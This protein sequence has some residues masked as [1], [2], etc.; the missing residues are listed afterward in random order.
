MN[1]IAP[2]TLDPRLQADAVFTQPAVQKR[3]T[4]IEGLK[5]A[6]RVH[7]AR[8]DAARDRG[9]LLIGEP[10]ISTSRAVDLHPGFAD[11]P[12]GIRMGDLDSLTINL[13]LTTRHRDYEAEEAL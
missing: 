10:L 8:V 2:K 12:R 6:I 11:T 5:A 9:E 3:H 4:S 13:S 7:Q 1:D